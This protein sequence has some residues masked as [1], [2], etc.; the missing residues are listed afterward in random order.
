MTKPVYHHTKSRVDDKW[1]PVRI[2]SYDGDMAKV[3][4]GI[5]SFIQWLPVTELKMFDGSTKVYDDE[6][7]KKHFVV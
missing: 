7:A 3:E 2:L 5:L 4:H 6:Y 1:Y